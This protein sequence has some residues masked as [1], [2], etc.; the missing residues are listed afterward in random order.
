MGIAAKARGEIGGEGIAGA[1]RLKASATQF[2]TVNMAVN[3]SLDSSPLCRPSIDFR[4]I[5][6]IP[7]RDKQ[8]WEEGSHHKVALTRATGRERDKAT[9]GVEE[10]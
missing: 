7:E 6:A 4:T 10:R 5:A 2:R 8:L 9:L 1:H 3:A